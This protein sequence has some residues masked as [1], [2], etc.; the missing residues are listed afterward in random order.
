MIN[1]QRH[2]FLIA[3]TLL[4]L[5]PTVIAQN[6][7]LRKGDRLYDQQNYSEAEV[8]YR[9]AEAGPLASY[10]AGNAA[11]QQ[12]NYAEAVT[13]YLTAARTAADAPTKANALY[14][15]G[16]AQ[17][18]AGQYAEAIEAY[19]S[20]LRQRPNQPDAKQNLQIAIKKLREQ[21]E[22]PPPPLPPPPP[23]P[24]PKQRPRNN[25]LDQASSTRKREV[26]SSGLSPEAA[27]DLLETR[28]TRQEQENAQQYRQLAAPTRPSRVKKDW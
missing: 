21:Q 1:F 27:R 2:I 13:L 24:P 10:N 14:N 28:V 4:G 12:G 17:L 6:S 23:P 16:N 15:M 22:P 7:Q 11:Y 20:S 25:Y 5:A 3:L 19:E 9:D 8:A 26:P 18:R